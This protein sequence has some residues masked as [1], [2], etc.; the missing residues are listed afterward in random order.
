MIP[1]LKSAEYVRDY[2]VRLLFADGRQADVDFES[3]LWG[4]VFEPLRDAGVFQAFRLDE[5]LN[6]IV[7]PCGADFAPEFL[8]EMVEAQQGTSGDPASRGR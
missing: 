3:E 5:E 8:Y 6:T 2:T 1:K 4:E 7:W